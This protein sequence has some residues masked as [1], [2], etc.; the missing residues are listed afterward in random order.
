MNRGLVH[1]ASQDASKISLVRHLTGIGP[2]ELPAGQVLHGFHP[3]I[4]KRQ[5]QSEPWQIGCS[6]GAVTHFRAE[7]KEAE[8]ERRDA[9][10]KKRI[11][12]DWGTAEQVNRFLN[13]LNWVLY[14]AH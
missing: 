1:A 14:S 4:R 7:S 8:H 2:D 9:D 12:F 11:G 5:S 6:Q 13:E 10:E 3:E